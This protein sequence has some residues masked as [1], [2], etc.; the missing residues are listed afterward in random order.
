MTRYGLIID[1]T[2]CTGC[3]ACIIACKSENS[4]PPGVSWIRIQE[5]ETGE[6][7]YTT[8]Q[9]IPLLCMQCSDMPCARV[10]PS[11][12]ISRGNGG[13]VQIDSKRCACRDSH[14]C[15]DVCPIKALQISSGK[16]SYFPELAGSIEKETSE[17]HRNDVVEKCTLCS[18]RLDTGKLPACVQ[19]C[20]SQAMVFGDYDDTD[21]I[22]TKIVASGHAQSLQGYPDFNP[23]VL[24]RI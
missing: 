19:A 23:Q 3:Y 12:A 8:R 20:P 6:F 4:T 7:P 16:H 14:P 1:S 10:C 2:R 18:H 15:M 22:L 5:Y 21:G 13:I 17:A 9:Y 24:Y 11:E